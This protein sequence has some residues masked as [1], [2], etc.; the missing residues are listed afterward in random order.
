MPPLKL[1]DVA[2]RDGPLRLVV[3]CDAKVGHQQLARSSVLELE[4]LVVKGRAVDRAATRPA[5][6]VR[7]VAALHYEARDDA[8]HGRP[9]V[10]QPH[11]PL[12]GDLDGTGFAGAEAAEVLDGAR[13][14]L[15]AQA[16][17]D[18]PRVRPSHGEVHVHAVSHRVVHLGHEEAVPLHVWPQL[19]EAGAQLLP[20]ARRR[21]ELPEGVVRLDREEEAPLE[22]RLAAH[23]HLDRLRG[24]VEPD[25]LCADVGGERQ[26]E[27]HLL[28]ALRPL[29]RGRVLGGW[30]GTLRRVE[31]ED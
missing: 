10:V 18:A 26:Q 14:R 31:G 12:L 27:R 16:E 28:V 25:L 13:A 5:G 29:H 9:R 4:I 3:V 22:H 15:A 30:A 1:G 2:Q 19:G 7:H 8:V 21:L 20:A 11:R 24:E 23:R 6:A 17:D